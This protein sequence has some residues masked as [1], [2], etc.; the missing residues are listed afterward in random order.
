MPAD[1]PTTAVAA[2]RDCNP[3]H[4]PNIRMVLQLACNLPFTQCVSGVL[5]Q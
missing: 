2:T 5:A 3:V 1:R 4:F